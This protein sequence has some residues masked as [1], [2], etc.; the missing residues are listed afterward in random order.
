MHPIKSIL[1]QYH[2]F[3]PAYQVQLN[4]FTGEN[5]KKRMYRTW[6]KTSVTCQIEQMDIDNKIFPIFCQLRVN[7]AVRAKRHMGRPDQSYPQST[8]SNHYENCRLCQAVQRAGTFSR[9]GPGLVTAV[10]AAMWH[11]HTTP[12]SLY[13][14]VL[15]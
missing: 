15:L 6:S 9:A 8:A 13:L 5:H 4:V 11:T 12:G 14:P 3:C 7:A 2:T 1:L 10:A